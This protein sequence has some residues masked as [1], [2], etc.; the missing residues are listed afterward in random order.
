MSDR[1]LPIVDGAPACPFVAFE[2]DRDERA[3]SPDH[4]HRCYAEVRPAPRALAHQEAYCLSSAFPVC[5]TFQ[6]WARREAAHS[7]AGAVPPPPEDE[8]PRRNPPR[9]WSAPPPWLGGVEAAAAGGE[10]ARDDGAAPP[11]AAGEAATPGFLAG[12]SA[13][14]GGLVG[15]PA[16]RIASAAASREREVDERA[17]EEP[18]ERAAA[19]A[20]AGA[21]AAGAGAAATYGA[22]P[23]QAYGGRPGDTRVANDRSDDFEDLDDDV[24]EV[25]EDDDYDDHEAERRGGPRAA[26]AGAG[27]AAGSGLGRD[28]RPRVGDTR[29][30]QSAEMAG[31]SWERPRRAEAYPTL[32]TRVGLPPLPRVGVMAIALVVVAIGLFFLPQLLGVGNKPG[33]SGGGG[34]GTTPAPTAAA[35]SISLEPTAPPAPTPQTYVVKSGDTLSKIANRFNVPLDQLIAA[36]KDTISNPDALQIGD[37]L[38]I[39]APLPEEV[40]GSAEPSAAP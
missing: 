13:P 1:G 25:D 21:A 11:D 36:N 7:R 26:G 29:R 9:D 34:G 33:Q 3:S 12:R 24:D 8:A 35:P 5:P 40:G 31:P 28:R 39:P 4:R 10:E 30:G 22:G 23:R 32:R 6:D 16:D 27:W 18:V 15:S 19:G 37:T 14:G 17:A 38:I 2:D 20:A